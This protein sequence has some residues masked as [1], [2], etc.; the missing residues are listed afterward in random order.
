[1]DSKLLSINGKKYYFDVNAIMDWCLSC[2]QS[3]PQKETEI[4]EGY[5]IND[6]GDLVMMTKVVRESKVNNTQDD[7]IRYDFIKMLINPF[8]GE[9]FNYDNINYN[10][11]LIV[12]YNTLIKMGFL[13]EITE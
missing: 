5:D 7:T 12:M 1:M 8:L 6:D 3:P 9:V 2:S 10:M 4:N 13:I 11:S